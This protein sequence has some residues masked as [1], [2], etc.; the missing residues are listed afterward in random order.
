MKRAERGVVYMVWGAK[1]EPALQ[2]SLASLRAI[3]PELPVEVIRIAADPGTNKSLLAKAEMFARS[4]FGE[5]L[6]LDADTVIL[7][8]LD[9]GFAKARQFGLACCICEAPWAR[10]YGG[11]AGS[12]DMIEYNTGVLFFTEAAKPVFTLWQEMAPTL[13]SSIRFYLN[14]RLVTMAANDQAS[15]AA[16]IERT[17][18][19]PFIL[20]RNW[21]FRAD[22]ERLFFGPLKIWHS[23]SRVPAAI[24][25]ICAY[26]RRSDAII[27]THACQLPGNSG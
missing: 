23:H 14:G 26:Y 18:L 17:G 25:E 1:I 13:D 7:D 6:Y 3:H 5:T 24:N 11:L 8:R 20:P 10:R 4:P 12:G 16:A 22:L 19:S 9:F 21:N 27:Q 15:F 2:R